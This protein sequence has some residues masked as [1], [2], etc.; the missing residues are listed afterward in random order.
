MAKEQYHKRLSELRP[1]APNQVWQMDV[2]YVFVPRFGWYYQIDIIDYHS[3]YLLAQRL[4]KSYCSEEALKTLEQA[5]KEAK[6]LAVPLPA[7]GL[8]TDNGCTFVCL[9]NRG[10][11]QK[12]CLQHFRTGYRMPEHNGI[13]ERFHGTVKQECLLRAEF[14]DP[15]E[16]EQMLRSYGIYYN[17]ERPHWSCDLE[18]PAQNLQNVL[19]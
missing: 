9:W 6:R 14:S 18:T 4:T 19:P 10:I 1:Q 3:R 17:Y 16:A 15:V 7:K 5:L 2:M 12:K 8:V 11:K 13:I